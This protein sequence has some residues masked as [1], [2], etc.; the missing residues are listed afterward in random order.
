VASTSKSK[1]NDQELVE[2]QRALVTSPTVGIPV[3]DEETVKTFHSRR[4]EQREAYGQFVANSDIY[5][6]DGTVLVFTKGTP[7]PV[8]HVEKWDLETAGVVDRVATPEEARRAGPTAN[9]PATALLT[10]E[11]VGGTS[12]QASSTEKK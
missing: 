2:L 3:A 11:N 9:G 4:A 12:P 10:D 7:V 8:E 6:P 5:P 1:A